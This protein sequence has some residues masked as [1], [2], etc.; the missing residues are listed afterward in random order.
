M[1]C[2]QCRYEFCWLCMGDYRNHSSET[3][4]SLCNSFEDV[5]AAG[6]GKDSDYLEKL[7]LDLQLKKLDFYKTRFMEHFK[8]IQFAQKKKQDIQS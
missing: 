7:E 2:S 1:T 4:K 8:A 5:V 3:G 6:R